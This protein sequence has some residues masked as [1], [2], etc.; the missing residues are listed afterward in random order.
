VY[1]E[2]MHM[3]ENERVRLPLFLTEKGLNAE[4]QICCKSPSSLNAAPT[5]VLTV[6]RHG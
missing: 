2:C 1:Q 3:S 4:E 5:I 6:P